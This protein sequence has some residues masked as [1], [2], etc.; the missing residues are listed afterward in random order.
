MSFRRMNKKKWDMVKRRQ[1]EPKTMVYD[2]LFQYSGG[3]TF[4]GSVILGASIRL[5]VRVYKD[6]EE[7]KF[8]EEPE[9]DNTYF[10][11]IFKV[12]IDREKVF[13]IEKNV[14]IENLFC[15]HYGFE[16][17]ETEAIGYTFDQLYS[18]PKSEGRPT[19][20][21]L[22]GVPCAETIEISEDEFREFICLHIE[23]FDIPDNMN[24][25]APAVA[26]V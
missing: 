15:K 6:G 16:R 13:A 11:N 26:F 20:R 12:S 10:G 25:Q 5:A 24:V 9:C 17:I 23:D 18:F 19:P 4:N 14:Y 7:I 2:F 21:Y 22:E 8:V 3:D 1:K